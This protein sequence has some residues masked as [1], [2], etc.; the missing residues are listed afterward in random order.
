MLNLPKNIYVIAIVLSLNLSTM[1]MMV[2]IG[3]LI[4]KQLAPIDSL[5]T[6]PLAVMIIALA[7]S[8]FP[9]AIL[10]RK[11]GRKNGVRIGI[12]VAMFACILGFVALQQSNFY[13]FTIACLAFGFNAAFIQ[14]GRFIIL[15]NAASDTQKTDGLTLALLAN[16]AAAFIGPELG[17]WGRD[18]SSSYQYVGSFGCLFVVLAIALIVLNS[19]QEQDRNIAG[20]AQQANETPLRALFSRPMFLVAVVS[21][22]T[23]YALMALIMT[24]TPISMHEFHEHTLAS[25][26]V[27]IQSHIIAM[28]LPSLLTGIL[29]KRGMRIS[30][31]YIGLSM[32]VLVSLI[33]FMGVDIMHYWFALVMLGIGWNFL[34]MACTTLL[35]STYKPEDRFKAEASNDFAIFSAQALATFMAGWLLYSLSWNGILLIVMLISLACAAFIAICSR[36]ADKQ[37]NSS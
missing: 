24:A 27:V 34:F 7:A 21:A 37:V 1:T 22:A 31:V 2:L 23:G 9:A 6:L 3:G 12:L 25:T 11:F 26:K 4:G 28:F 17:E 13:L 15:E 29:L 35:P 14:Q 10:M 18:L 36:I 33:G 5:A 20:N 30:L 16:L 32:Y 19:Y 8:T